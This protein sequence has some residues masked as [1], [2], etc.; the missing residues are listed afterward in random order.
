MHLRR[1]ILLI[2][3]GLLGITSS[4]L[5]QAGWNSVTLSW[6]TP[7]DDSLSALSHARRDACEITLFPQCLVR[8][9]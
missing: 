8:I 9:H 7:G 1:I 6:T 3:S 2:A 4:S 5:A